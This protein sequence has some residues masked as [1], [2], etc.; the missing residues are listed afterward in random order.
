[1][2]TPKLLFFLMPLILT[3]CQGAS[4]RT[5]KQFQS[6]TGRLK[7]K[8]TGKTRSPISSSDSEIINNDLGT[9]I[10][11]FDLFK[12]NTAK[13]K[14][15]FL[16][17]V[18][19]KIEKEQNPEGGFYKLYDFTDGV[20]KLTLYNNDGFYLKE[21]D[22]KNNKVLLNKKISIGMAKDAFLNLLKA[23]STPYDTVIIKNDEL[24]FETV[25]IFNNSKLKQ[26]KMGQIAE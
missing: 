6:D 2:K 14:S 3:A 22:I 16:D 17:P 9:D 1:M 10:L 15:L 19:L 5:E 21:G 25:Y 24:T 8:D 7:K 26:I 12:A 20:N 23:A 13:I 11:A 18:I 4:N